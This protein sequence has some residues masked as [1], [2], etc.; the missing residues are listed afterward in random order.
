[1]VIALVLVGALYLFQAPRPLQFRIIP[2]GGLL[3]FVLLMAVLGLGCLATVVIDQVGW[4]GPIHASRD[5]GYAWRRS[6]RARM[7][8]LGGVFG[9]WIL[10]AVA[11]V[12][13]QAYFAGDWSRTLIAAAATLWGLW[14]A[15]NLLI[16]AFSPAVVLAIDNTGIYTGRPNRLIPWREIG[17][18][19]V[20][21]DLKARQ[22]SL[23]GEDSGGLPRSIQVDLAAA[24][25][26]ARPFLDLVGEV[27][28][29]V[30]VIWP[31]ARIASFG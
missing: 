21:G 30:E 7:H 14:L 12:G 13:Q 27:A 4:A 18:I 17:R 8:Y 9:L 6:L 15:V 11:D 29:Q 25:L 16:L 19:T 23:V 26:Q 22:V 24:G 5:G 10:P 1:M 2:D 20:E 31:R 28:P 3:P